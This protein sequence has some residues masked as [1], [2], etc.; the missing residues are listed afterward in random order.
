MAIKV[1]GL[2]AGG[3]A[4]V[5]IEILR[6]YNS[7]E[8]T[9]LLDAKPELKGKNLMGV[10]VLGNDGLLPD[11]KRDGVTHFFVGLGSTGDTCPRRRLFEFAI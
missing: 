8:L 2:G 11:L 9:G 3:H 10:P 1:I 4:K 7:Y 5:V 6:Y